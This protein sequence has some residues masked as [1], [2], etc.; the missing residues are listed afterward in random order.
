LH[1]AALLDLEQTNPAHNEPAKQILDR[2]YS[3]LFLRTFRV[4]KDFEW[5]KATIIAKKT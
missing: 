1:K 3:S 5:M 4:E 2:H